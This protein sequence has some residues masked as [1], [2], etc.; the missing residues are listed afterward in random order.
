MKFILEGLQPNI[1]KESSLWSATI[2][3]LWPN[4]LA[5]P[6]SYNPPQDV[7]PPLA[8]LLITFA[9][10]IFRFSGNFDF[11]DIGKSV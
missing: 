1:S 2:T 9:A 3:L 11:K 4:A 8:K 6:A 7:H 5:K 10:S